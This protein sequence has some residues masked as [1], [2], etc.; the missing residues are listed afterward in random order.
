MPKIL[1]MKESGET[2]NYFL[3]KNK[4]FTKKLKLKLKQK[5][6]WLGYPLVIPYRGFGSYSTQKAFVTGALVEDQ[7]L[8]KPDEKQSLWENISAMLKR[9]SGD[10]IPNAKISVEFNGNKEELI[11]KEN[12]IFKTAFPFSPIAKGTNTY[13]LVGVFCNHLAMQLVRLKKN[14]LGKVK[15]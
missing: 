14:S 6:G 8:K 4:S 10:Q 2:L 12:G 13:P 9:Y 11:S 3:Q 7:G 15:F 1:F 5:L